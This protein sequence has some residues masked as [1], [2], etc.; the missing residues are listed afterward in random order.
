VLYRAA[1]RWGS[2]VRIRQPELDELVHA[3]ITTQTILMAPEPIK[4]SPIWSIA[5]G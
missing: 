4:I 5:E 2:T 3:G 1:M